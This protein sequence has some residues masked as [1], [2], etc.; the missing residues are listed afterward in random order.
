M[1][2][3]N[4]TTALRANPAEHPVDNIARARAVIELISMAAVAESVP[5]DIGEPILWGCIHA[6]DLLDDALAALDDKGAVR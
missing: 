3:P 4:D 6:Q 2:A 1:N 5:S